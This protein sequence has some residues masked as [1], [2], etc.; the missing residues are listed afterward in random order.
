[1]LRDQ[2]ESPIWVINTTARVDRLLIK[3]TSQTQ[4]PEGKRCYL[5]LQPAG[6]T[7]AHRLGVLPDSGEATVRVSAE[8]SRMMPARLLVS[9]EDENAPP[10]RAPGEVIEIRDEWLAPVTSQI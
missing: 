7:E 10:A 2:A 8:L 6:S 9:I 1:M 3:A 5:W 4:V